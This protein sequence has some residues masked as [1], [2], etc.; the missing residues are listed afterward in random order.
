LTKVK[1]IFGVGMN[2]KSNDKKGLYTLLFCLFAFV[3]GGINGFLGTGGGIIF[4]L[5]LSLITKNE[6]KD[7]FATSLCATIVLSL[8]GSYSY[9]KTASIDF[10]LIYACF[11]FAIVGGMLGALI[12]DKIKTKWLNVGF[13]IL[14]IYSGTCL[15]FR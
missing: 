12:T 10:D 11:P 8:V 4:V 15:I 1:N 2:F 7:N 3:G 13:A 5:L 6:A 14:I 9:F